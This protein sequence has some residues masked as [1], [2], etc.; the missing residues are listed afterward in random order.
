[1]DRGGSDSD[2]WYS[3]ERIQVFSILQIREG[4]LPLGGEVWVVLY[5]PGLETLYL[6]DYPAGRKYG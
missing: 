2:L 6:G 4:G 1:M 3:T 5:S